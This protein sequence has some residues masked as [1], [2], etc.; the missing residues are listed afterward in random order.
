MQVVVYEPLLDNESCPYPLINQLDV[1][2]SKVDLI[3]AN[4]LD[5]NLRDVQDK[6]YSRD[7]YHEN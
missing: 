4:R 6:V 1:F 7:L 5:E 3:I 2:K